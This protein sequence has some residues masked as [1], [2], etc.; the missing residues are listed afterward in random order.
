M[1]ASWERSDADFPQGPYRIEH[2]NV[3][4]LISHKRIPLNLRKLIPTWARRLIVNRMVD[5]A[6]H[7]HGNVEFENEVEHLKLFVQR[8]PQ[9]TSWLNT[10]TSQYLFQE[11]C[12]QELFKVIN[13]AEPD[14]IINVADQDPLGQ[15]AAH[16]A[17]RKGVTSVTWLIAIAGTHPTVDAPVSDYAVLGGRSV[18]DYY[19][20]MGY[21]KER[22]KILG[23]PWLDQFVPTPLG[24]KVLF[25]TE[26]CRA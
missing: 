13:H 26:N 16:A 20:Q 19:V 4:A 2:F 1:N 11:A 23:H 5:Y 25:G 15:C 24:D 9:Y 3:D 10:A 14:L 17:H 12:E 21:P 7:E 6:V 8:N 18:F 22:M